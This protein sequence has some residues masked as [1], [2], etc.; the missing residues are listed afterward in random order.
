VADQGASTPAHARHAAAELCRL[1]T[2]SRRSR[3]RVDAGAGRGRRVGGLGRL[4]PA[5]QK[6]GRGL[7]APPFPF[8]NFLEFLFPKRLMQFLKPL[9]A[10]SEVEVKRRIVP[11]KILY[12]FA[13]IVEFK[14]QTEF[15]S[16]I[17]TLSRFLINL[18]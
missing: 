15:E 2:A 3:P 14:F 5:C 6:R 11:H 4:R 13:I 8:S 12:N 18:F 1:A 9:Q 10:F 17:K 16:Q 7:L